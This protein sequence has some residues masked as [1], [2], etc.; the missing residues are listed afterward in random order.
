LTWRERVGCFV[1]SDEHG[2]PFK[3]DAPTKAFREIVSAA[4]L[5]T[6]LTLH[7]LRHT[8][9]TWAVANGVDIVAVQNCLGHSKPSTAYNL[10]SHAVEGGREKA[11]AA[12]GVTMRRIRSGVGGKPGSKLAVSRIDCNQ[13]ATMA[14][15]PSSDTADDLLESS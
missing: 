12:V 7:S 10:Y 5:P 1:F 9:A 8:F 13:T 2:R 3:L 4:E 14:A 15:V 6:E 11:V